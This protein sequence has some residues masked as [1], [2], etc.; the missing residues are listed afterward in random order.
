LLKDFLHAVIT[1]CQVSLVANKKEIMLTGKHVYNVSDD[2][3]VSDFN[4]RLGNAITYTA[5]SLTKA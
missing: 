3:F 2:R 4:Q 5:K 1:V